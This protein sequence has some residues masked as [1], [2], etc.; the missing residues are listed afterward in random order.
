MNALSLFITLGVQ[1]HTPEGKDA[2]ANLCRLMRAEAG[3]EIVPLEHISHLL[4]S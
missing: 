1:T 3:R 4:F 2:F